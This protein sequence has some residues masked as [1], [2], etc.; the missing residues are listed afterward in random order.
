M[1]LFAGDRNVEHVG[2]ESSDDAESE[3]KI[4]RRKR[5][6]E[7][8]SHQGWRDH[9]IV[10][11]LLYCSLHPPRNVLFSLLPLLSPSESESDSGTRVLSWLVG[12]VGND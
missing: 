7:T 1:T 4:K 11:M 8:A 2:L 5:D 10:R 9:S 6:R 3:A 12:V